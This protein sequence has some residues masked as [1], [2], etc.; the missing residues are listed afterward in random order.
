[1]ENQNLPKN[2]QKLINSTKL[3]FTLSKQTLLKLLTKLKN[4]KIKEL[5]KTT[6]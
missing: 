5:K 6:I 4:I 3:H 2:I 1:M